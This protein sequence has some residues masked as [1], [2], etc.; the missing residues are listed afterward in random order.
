[1]R[2][3]VLSR[4]PP[5]LP[6]A[7]LRAVR[8]SLAAARLG[9]IA[10]LIG[11]FVAPIPHHPMDM[12]AAPHAKVVLGTLLGLVTPW[13]LLPALRVTPRT[14]TET[15]VPA[16]VAGETKGGGAGGATALSQYRVGSRLAGL[17]Q[18]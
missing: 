9:A 6:T 12:F 14:S 3:F 8:A 7:Q 16:Q 15:R 1:L 5:D 11:G 4:K 17:Q 13:L 2:G 10:A 18:A